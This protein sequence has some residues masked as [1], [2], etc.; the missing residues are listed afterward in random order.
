M[1]VLVRNAKTGEIFVFV[2]G[3]PELIQKVSTND[4]SALPLLVKELSFE[5]FRVIGVGY[6]CVESSQLS[7]YL[8]MPR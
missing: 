4:C 7:H 1:S 2:K 5:G 3:S 8:K 6:K